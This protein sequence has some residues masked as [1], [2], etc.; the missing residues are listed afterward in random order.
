MSCFCSSHWLIAELVA[1]VV[2]L[3]DH[4]LLVELLLQ[5]ALPLEGEVGGADDQNALDETAQLQFLDEQPGHDRLAGAGVV[6]QQEA[7]R[8]S[9]KR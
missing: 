3:D 4:E 2:A 6:G 7:D 5:F 1:D 8:A 9:F